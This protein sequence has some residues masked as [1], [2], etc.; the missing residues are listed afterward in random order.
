MRNKH[1]SIC[2]CCNICS[3]C[4]FLTSNQINWLRSVLSANALQIILRVR[5]VSKDQSQRE[6]G[7][8][9]ERKNSFSHIVWK[10]EG[11]DKNRQSKRR[12]EGIFFL[13]KVWLQ[14]KE[15]FWLTIAPCPTAQ[16]FVLKLASLDLLP[17]LN[18]INACFFFV[19]FFWLHHSRLNS[20]HNQCL[21]LLQPH[22][23][24]VFKFKSPSA[25]MTRSAD[26][27]SAVS[28]FPCLT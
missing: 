10:A 22:P 7:R 1:I 19:F 5:W 25:V 6:Q 28:A 24:F 14:I 18:S 17:P 20:W 9:K 27:A 16:P 21:L 12:M 23:S 3:T 8:K 4:N 11:G 26:W 13:Q 15:A 2:L